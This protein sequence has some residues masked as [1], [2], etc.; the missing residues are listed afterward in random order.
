M[1]KR[2]VLIV[3]VIG[4][5]LCIPRISSALQKC[6]SS[7]TNQPAVITFV[8]QTENAVNIFWVNYECKEVSYGSVAAGSSVRQETYDGHEWV[9]RD[10]SG[11]EVARRVASANENIVVTVGETE[12]DIPST[13]PA[14]SV[15]FD[16]RPEGKWQA[17]EG[18]DGCKVQA[19]TKK[20]GLDPFYKKYCDYEGILIASSNKVP[21]KALQVAWNIMA[22]MLQGHPQIIEQFHKLNMHVGIVAQPEGITMLPEYRF[23]KDDKQTN[24]DERARGLGGTPSVPLSSGAEENLLCYKN[25]PYLGENIFLHEFSHT[26]KNSGI[27]LI[28]PKFSQA[29]Q[30]AYDEARKKGLW[31]D[32]YAISGVEE[33]WAEGVQDYFDTNLES[34]PANGIH[35]EINTRAELKEYDPTLFGIIDTIFGGFAWSPI[36]PQ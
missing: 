8:N 28:D 3:L 15:D 26:M 19:T 22:N 1:L 27:D 14:G 31:A 20:T 17:V 36:C 11:N 18:Y 10:V 2:L 25:D 33:Y 7:G 30:T 9:L 24:W 32:T 5:L 34:I 23:L 4:T 29:L 13:Q 35:N 6:S 12:G 21:D 16:Y